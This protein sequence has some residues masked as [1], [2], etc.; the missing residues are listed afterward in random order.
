MKIEW[1]L[2]ECISAKALVE[3]AYYQWGT[4]GTKL[5]GIQGDQDYT[6]E[7]FVE[8]LAEIDRLMRQAPQHQK[9]V[10]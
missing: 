2:Y 4:Y 7:F 6:E 9:R 1:P 3:L 5:D 8:S 10:V